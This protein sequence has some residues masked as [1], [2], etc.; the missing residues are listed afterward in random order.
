[1]AAPKSGGKRVRSA[2]TGRFLKKGV[3]KSRPKTTV[4][5]AVKKRRKSSKKRK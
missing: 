1:M 4:A 3:A 2:I 5:E